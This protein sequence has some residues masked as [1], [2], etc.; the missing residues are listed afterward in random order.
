MRVSAMPREL[1]S[2]TQDEERVRP[3]QARHNRLI[4]LQVALAGD[5]GSGNLH[6]C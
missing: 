4:E 2:V 6:A 1:T 3:A 5:A